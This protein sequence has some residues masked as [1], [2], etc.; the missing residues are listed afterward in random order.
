MMKK[1]IIILASL[2]TI[3][4][5]GM[6]TI[7]SREKPK[8]TCSFI[9][10]GTKIN[11]SRNNRF[12]FS[13]EVGDIQYSK[14]NII[15]KSAKK[16]SHDNYTIHIDKEYRYNIDFNEKVIK[17]KMHCP[18]LS[19]VEP[20]IASSYYC[21]GY[22]CQINDFSYQYK[23][24]FTSPN[25]SCILYISGKDA[26]NKASDHLAVCYENVLKKGLYKL[27]DTTEKNI[28]LPAL[29]T[30]IGFPR[31]KAAPIA[32]DTVFNFI[33]N[34]FKAYSSITFFVK[35]R[36]DFTSYKKLI[37]K[38]GELLRKIYLFYYIHRDKDSILSLLPMDIRD[39]IV[40]LI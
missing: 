26:I 17:K 40:Q 11:K 29:S 38:H 36:S 23:V 3:F 14:K 32:I 25:T 28:A 35:K 22:E 24:Q 34:N 31:N 5:Q 1:D 13:C 21:W 16:H 10:Y 15:Y 18:V 2:A 27:A 20:M 30:N 19:I 7:L 12:D 33:K 8:K 4:I 39:Y 37:I 9:Y 6:E